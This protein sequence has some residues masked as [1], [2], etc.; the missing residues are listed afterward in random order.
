MIENTAQEAENKTPEEEIAVEVTEDSAV[1]TEGDGDELEKYTKGVSKRINKLNAKTRAAEERAAQLERLA[2]EKEKELQQYRAYSQQQSSAIL[3]KEEEALKSKS[4]QVDDIYRK[5]VESGDADLMSK[6]D[7]LKNDISIQKEKLRVAKTRQP[8]QQAQENYQPYQ[9]QP[10]QAQAPVQPT[11]QAKKW[12]AK[13]SWYGNAEDE[14]HT[15]ATQFAYFTHFNLINEGFEPDS[16]EYYE[17]LDSRV[18]KVYPNLV[19]ED[20]LAEGENVEAK[21]ERPAVQ[22]V[23]S[24]TTS[25]RQ[26]TRGKSN[27]VKF[28]KS[29]VERLR[30]LKPHNM[31]EEQ[32]LKVV[33][34]E[35]QKIAQREAR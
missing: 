29:E 15:Q 8:K 11:E 30:G 2:M 35:K 33:A 24:T 25:G 18:K 13:N 23:A 14:E 28:T 5:A 10:Q 6:A 1:S 32:W 19:S 17:A 31:S 16:E 9:E 26:Q 21:E 4:A 27:G 3:A 22:R 34:K 20:N 7:S 12:H